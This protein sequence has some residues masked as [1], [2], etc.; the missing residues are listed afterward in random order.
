MAPKPNPRNRDNVAAMKLARDKKFAATHAPVSESWWIG[1]SRDE[2][3]RE[4]A[5]RQATRLATGPNHL[6]SLGRA[7]GK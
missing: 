7:I 4:V 5:Q 2:F 3:N 1:K 6:R